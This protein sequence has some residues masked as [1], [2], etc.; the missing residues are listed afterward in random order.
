M[1][2]YDGGPSAPFGSQHH[3][4]TLPPAPGLSLPGAKGDGAAIEE[5]LQGKQTGEGYPL[6]GADPDV[7]KQA[8]A[9]VSHGTR[10]ARR[11]IERA[12]KSGKPPKLPGSDSSA[13]KYGY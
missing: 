1:S 9:M 4:D 13:K 11:Q 10:Q 5:Y 8:H 12:A 7:N 3:D 2:G 6:G